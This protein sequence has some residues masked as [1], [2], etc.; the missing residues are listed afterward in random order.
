MFS[1]MSAANV[2]SG[3]KIHVFR[4]LTMTQAT[5]I[6]RAIHSTAV[7]NQASAQRQ[8]SPVKPVTSRQSS[9]QTLQPAQAS[10]PSIQENNQTTAATLPKQRSTNSLSQSSGEHVTSRYLLLVKIHLYDF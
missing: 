10:L 7:Q 3:L 2:A 4:C 6:C 8:P 9:Q 5:S 1:F